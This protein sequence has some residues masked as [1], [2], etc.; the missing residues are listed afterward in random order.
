MNT[1]T[2]L[3]I[4]S[5]PVEANYEEIPA[6]VLETGRAIITR[7]KRRNESPLV[8]KLPTQG[9]RVV[10]SGGR[11][12]YFKPGVVAWVIGASE[13]TVF[14]GPD[15]AATEVKIVEFVCLCEGGGQALCQYG[16]DIVFP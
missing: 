11:A 9:I 6:A 7:V 13:R 5:A 12:S 10:S 14:L 8:E 4:N 16:R 1:E 2:L 3:C 15:G